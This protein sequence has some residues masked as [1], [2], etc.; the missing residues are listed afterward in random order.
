MALKL[1]FS[2]VSQE[3]VKKWAESLEN[4]ISHECESDPLWVG[5]TAPCI[6]AS[7][8][9]QDSLRGVGLLGV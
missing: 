1:F 7:H 4:L 5:V 8:T 6:H 2:R 9:T 3:E